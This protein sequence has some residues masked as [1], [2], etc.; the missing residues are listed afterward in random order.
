[1]ALA[2]LSAISLP[3]V[4][5]AQQTIFNVPSADVLDKGKTYAEWDFT[6]EDSNAD[7]AVTPHSVRGM[8]HGVEAGFNFSSVTLTHP[9]E[10]ALTLAPTLKW[11]FFESPGHSVAVFAGDQLFLPIRY[12]AYTI[13]NEVYLSVAVT[14][15]PGT[16]VSVGGYDFTRQTIDPANRGGIQASIEQPLGQRFGLST[17]WYS[18]N[19]SVGYMT[20]GGSF[21][22]GKGITFSAACQMGNRDLMSGN[23]SLLLI[24]GW[25]PPSRG[26]IR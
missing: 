7:A 1:V 16:R 18:G 2:T 23:H 15:K 3:G 9:G 24:V 20:S 22:L 17:D 25:N 26:G 19:N 14:L 4:S 5:H 13:G 11:K 10:D 6:M 8:G 12:G 21:K